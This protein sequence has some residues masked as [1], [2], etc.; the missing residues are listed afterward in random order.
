MATGQQGNTSHHPVDVTD[1]HA[2]RLTDSDETHGNLSSSH[3]CRAATGHAWGGKGG[4]VGS[5]S[6]RALRPGHRLSRP[7]PGAR[8]LE[9]SSSRWALSEPHPEKNS[10]TD[11]FRP[12]LRK[13][14]ARQS[15]STSI[16]PR[17]PLKKKKTPVLPLI[18]APRHKPE[19]QLS[20]PLASHPAAIYDNLPRSPLRLFTAT[21]GEPRQRHR[22]HRPPSRRG[23]P[24]NQGR[25]TC[26][27]GTRVATP[28]PPPLDAAQRF[29][30]RRALD[31]TPPCPALLL[32]AGGAQSW[33]PPS[34]GCP[35]LTPAVGSIERRGEALHISGKGTR[36]RDGRKH[37]ET[38][39]E[40]ER[41]P[42]DGPLPCPTP[43]GNGQRRLGRRTSG[44]NTFLPPR[45]S[46]KMDHG[47]GE[48]G[49]K[50]GSLQRRHPDNSP[51][52]YL[53]WRPRPCRAVAS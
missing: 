39:A 8:P 21:N 44:I 15:H 2:P 45:S 34:P 47:G 4:A 42:P 6:S 11:R 33:A 9:G 29:R 35:T 7:R 14:Q 5:Q 32:L 46:A 51:M 40:G 28:R 20:S 31:D 3:I 1:Y 23:S 37:V 12:M 19:N 43:R 53:P 17:P 18:S 30:S 16:S 24:G 38:W 13:K 22:G 41:D 49:G 10:P 25:G 50:G 36:T 48:W 26:C 52:R 27:R